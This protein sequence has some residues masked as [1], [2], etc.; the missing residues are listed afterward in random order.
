MLDHRPVGPGNSSSL[1][2]CSSG[3]S[4]YGGIRH[5][6]YFVTFMADAD[7]CLNYLLPAQRNSEIV[8]SLRRT[9]EYPLMMMMD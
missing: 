2:H 7:N 9:K 5:F 3:D 6:H 1:Q 4:G 8:S